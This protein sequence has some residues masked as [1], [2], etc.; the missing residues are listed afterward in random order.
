[1]ASPTTNSADAGRW[2]ALLIALRRT[3]RPD[4]A[5]V[6]AYVSLLQHQTGWEAYA[7]FLAGHR[8]WIDGLDRALSE[9]GAPHRPLQDGPPGPPA[10]EAIPPPRNRA[11]A[12]GYL[13]VLEAFRQGYAVL[14]RRIR[15]LAES[16]SER[17]EADG[18]W[19]ELARQ[20]AAVPSSEQA[21]VLQGARDAFADWE[22]RMAASLARLGLRPTGQGARAA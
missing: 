15:G 7:E 12:L 1:M 4:R 20:L 8:A 13:Y 2:P 19:K 6:A 22:R 21:A 18:A 11:H 3:P 17:H 9:V 14:A 10:S 5:R 16:S